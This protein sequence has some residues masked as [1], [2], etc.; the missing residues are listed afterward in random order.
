MLRS[1]GGSPASCASA[2]ASDAN[3]FE[4]PP[5]SPEKLMLKQASPWKP[6][7]NVLAPRI[8]ELQS[9]NFADVVALES[10]V[11]GL[12]LTPSVLSRISP[13]ML[14]SQAS[15]LAS[16]GATYNYLQPRPVPISGYAPFGVSTGMP[17]ASIESLSGSRRAG[18]SIG[19]PGASIDSLSG[20]R[21]S[22]ASA[23]PNRMMHIASRR[24]PVSQG[25]PSVSSQQSQ[26]WK[27]KSSGSSETLPPVGSMTMRSLGGPSVTGSIRGGNTSQFT[28][29]FTASASVNA[30]KIVNAD[31]LKTRLAGSSAQPTAIY[32]PLGGSVNVSLSTSIPGTT[33]AR[34]SAAAVLQR[35]L[36]KAQS[37]TVGGTYAAVEGEEVS[38]V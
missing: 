34:H 2:S 16:G 22:M 17:G 25:P 21:R 5:S 27:M 6:P 24:V 9:R 31:I 30:V 28:S 11:A 15:A 10:S 26:T 38:R 4:T 36:P 19:M 14:P 33:L 3:P 18:V 7:G 12:D 29:A 13:T 35:K 1:L 32:R 23:T 20:S 37:F 8:P